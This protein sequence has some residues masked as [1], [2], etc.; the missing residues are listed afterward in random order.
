MDFFPWLPCFV[1][2]IDEGCVW[3]SL[4]LSWLTCDYDWNWFKWVS[5]SLPSCGNLVLILSIADLAVFQ[6]ISLT[7]V[8][9]MEREREGIILY[10][11]WTL[12]VW[13]GGEGKRNDVFEEMNLSPLQLDEIVF[14][15]L[16]FT[17]SC[18]IQFHWITFSSLCTVSVGNTKCFRWEPN[19][20]EL[21]LSFSFSLPIS[22]TAVASHIQHSHNHFS[23]FFLPSVDP[24]NR[25]LCGLDF[26]LDQKIFSHRW[27]FHE[28]KSFW[29]LE[30]HD[31]IMFPHFL[32]L[33]SLH[34]Q[35]SNWWAEEN[36]KMW[37]RRTTK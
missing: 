3:F 37:G 6:I 16:L 29:S 10:S 9:E 26:K 19:G 1:P 30:D 18:S 20:T 22:N 23:L 8:G 13:R 31:E 11:R 2:G 4:L 21:Q 35:V 33:K 15:F 24:L 17:R 36:F 7:L 12:L 28:C 32:R 25:D 34:G 5:N 27:E 14:D